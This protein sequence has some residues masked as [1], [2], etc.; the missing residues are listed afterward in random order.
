[1]N[2]SLVV[3]L[4]QVLFQVLRKIYFSRL[5]GETKVCF[6]ND[7][8]VMF[9]KD[10]FVFHGSKNWMKSIFG[11]KCVLLRTE[12]YSHGTPLKLVKSSLK[13]PRYGLTQKTQRGDR[14]KMSFTTGTFQEWQTQISML[15]AYQDI[16]P[17]NHEAWRRLAPGYPQ[18]ICNIRRYIV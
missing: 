4:G 14:A 18:R 11:L 7:N 1:M 16:N 15:I 3:L 6:N 17:F 8:Q 5:R 2:L 12:L 13:L 10:W 9:S